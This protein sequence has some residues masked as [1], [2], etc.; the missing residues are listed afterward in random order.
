LLVG[1]RLAARGHHERGLHERRAEP[2]YRRIEDAPSNRGKI[3]SAPINGFPFQ[4]VP[5]RFCMNSC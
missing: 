1:Y 5:F 3:I 2:E 4:S